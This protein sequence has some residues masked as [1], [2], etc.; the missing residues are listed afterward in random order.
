CGDWCNSYAWSSPVRSWR[1]TRSNP[2]PVNVG[3]VAGCGRG[4]WRPPGMKCGYENRKEVNCW[5]CNGTMGGM[6]ETQEMLD[7]AAK[8]NIRRDGLHEYNVG[9]PCEIR[10]QV[11]IRVRHGQTK[12]TV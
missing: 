11:S 2:P 8:H 9:M 10:C 1:S 12:R 6:E 7:F 4:D 5:E 3:H